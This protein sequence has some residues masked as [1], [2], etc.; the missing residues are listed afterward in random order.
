MLEAVST[1]TDRAAECHHLIERGALR[2]LSRE[3]TYRQLRCPASGG[4]KKRPRF[5]QI[6]WIL[7]D[8]EAQNDK[9]LADSADS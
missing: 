1:A 3:R 2:R 8:S 5:T 7:S 6:T 4:E 9:T